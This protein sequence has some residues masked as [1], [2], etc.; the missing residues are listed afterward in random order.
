MSNANGTDTDQTTVTVLALPDVYIIA[1]PNDTICEGEEVTL[2]GSGTSS[3]TWSSG[4]QNGVSFAPA[5]MGSNVYTV[6]GED[7]NGCQ[8]S[9]QI[10]VFVEACSNP[11]GFN[12]PD[13]VSPNGDGANDTWM[14]NGLSSYP[15]AKVS[16]FNRWGQEVYSG[17]ANSAPWDGTD[18]GKELP[19]ADYYY[20]LDLGNGQT[21]NGVVTLKR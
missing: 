21:Y 19:T 20:V 17:T 4:I 14:I 3:F 9:A 1:Q 15:D 10:E 8:Q 13:G 12:I 2:T 16:V 7:V 11:P 6:I 5:Q 18:K